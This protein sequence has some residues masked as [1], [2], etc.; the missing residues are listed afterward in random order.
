MIPSVHRE[1]TSKL[2]C[3][4]TKVNVEHKHLEYERKNEKEKQTSKKG[5]IRYKKKTREKYQITKW[6]EGSAK[7]I[8]L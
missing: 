5:K 8:S 1:W 4:T 3:I 7:L 2:K 6:Q